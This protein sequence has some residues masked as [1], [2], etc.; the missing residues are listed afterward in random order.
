VHRLSQQPGLERKIVASQFFIGIVL[1]VVG[2]LHS[3]QGSAALFLGAW[4]Q[5]SG[6][7]WVVYRLAKVPLSAQASSVLAAFY[8]AELG[9]WVIVAGLFFMAFGQILWLRDW[10]YVG[11]LFAAFI[12]AQS[13]NWLY[14]GIYRRTKS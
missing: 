4:V 3:P 10:P 5:A 6:G 14:P 13:L 8:I 7:A 2:L 9:K 1:A 11:F 12:A